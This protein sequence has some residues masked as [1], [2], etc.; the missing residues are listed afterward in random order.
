[1]AAGALLVVAACGGQSE[2]R[3]QSERNLYD[4][5][6]AELVAAPSAASSPSGDLRVVTSAVSQTLYVPSIQMPRVDPITGRTDWEISSPG[7]EM[8][9]WYV[10]AWL[11]DAT[12]QRTSGG[13][14]ARTIWVVRGNDYVSS[15]DLNEQD[16]ENA[17]AVGV[18]PNPPFARDGTRA[19]V[20]LVRGAQSTLVS[21]PIT[22]Q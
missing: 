12:A 5:T 13:W 11:E 16:A 7:Y 15:R 6:V 8:A 17:V 18:F 10:A 9:T 1:M 3:P 19:V 4:K 14:V 2:N 20:E 22:W 21:A